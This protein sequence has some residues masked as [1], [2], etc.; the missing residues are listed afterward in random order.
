M[1]IKLHNQETTTPKIHADF[2]SSSFQ[3][4]EKDLARQFSVSVSTIQRWCYKKPAADRGQD[5]NTGRR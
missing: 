5:R 2:L 1:G 3:H 4:Y